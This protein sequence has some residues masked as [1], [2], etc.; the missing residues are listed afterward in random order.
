MSD[1]PDETVYARYLR[2][3]ADW[4]KHGESQDHLSA[5]PML[6]LADT[7]E[8]QCHQLEAQLKQVV[9]R[10]APKPTLL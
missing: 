8:R 1:L 3:Y 10:L 9:E 6:V 5:L 2:I 4:S 7:I